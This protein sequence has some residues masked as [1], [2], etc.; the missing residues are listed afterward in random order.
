MHHLI[1]KV[2]PSSFNQIDCKCH[3]EAGIQILCNAGERCF[4]LGQ[5][6]DEIM[7]PGIQWEFNLYLFTQTVQSSL[8]SFLF[9]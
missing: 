8:S 2:W 4:D 9:L 7:E 5:E 6:A 3:T 1:R